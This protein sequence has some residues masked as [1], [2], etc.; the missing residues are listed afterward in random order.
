MKPQEATE[1]M[2]E[3]KMQEAQKVQMAQQDLHL[4]KAQKEELRARMKFAI[5]LQTAKELLN[6]TELM[7]VQKAKR[8]SRE[9]EAMKA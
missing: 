5:H 6:A 2:Q 4:Q 8:R 9:L 3:Q 7:K 1:L